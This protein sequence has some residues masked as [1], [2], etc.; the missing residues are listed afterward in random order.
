MVVGRGLV[1]TMEEGGGRSHIEFLK[2]DS[3]NLLVYL[4]R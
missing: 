1:G 3:Q 4:F 2:T